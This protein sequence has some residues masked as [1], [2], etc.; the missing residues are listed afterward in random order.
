[1]ITGCGHP[2]MERLVS[3]AETLFGKQ[4][5]GVVGGLHYTDPRGMADLDMEDLIAETPPGAVETSP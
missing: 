4:V 2:T 5:V 1:M 3:R